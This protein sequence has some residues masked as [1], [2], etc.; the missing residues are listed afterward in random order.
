MLL[1]EHAYS[2]DKQGLAT[3]TTRHVYHV[4]QRE[5]VDYWSSIEREY[6]PW[7]EKR[8]EIRA[9]VISPGGTVRMLDPKT[10]ADAATTQ[11]DNT[12]FS[13]RRTVRAPL[14]GVEAGAVV[15]VEVRT[16]QTR[17]QL[18]AGSVR[19]MVVGQYTQL[20][21]FRFSLEAHRQVPIRTALH[22]IP[23][24]SLRREETGKTVRYELELGPLPVVDRIDFNTPPDSS[25]EKRVE[26]S[27]GASWQALA[28]AYSQTIDEKIADADLSGFMEGVDL[29]GA[30]K[31]IAARLTARLHERV[32]YTGVEFSE[33]EIV[34]VTPAETIARGYG[35]CKD[36]STLLTALLRQ[37]G[38]D[39]RVALLAAGSDP[40]VPEGLPGL[41][42]FNH[43]IVRVGGDEPFWI[44]AT[45]EN[46]RVGVL[47]QMDEGRLVLVAA[48]DTTTLTPTPLS[49]SEDNWLKRTTTLRL[50]DFGRGST[51]VSTTLGGTI[52]QETRAT[53]GTG[54]AF[55]EAVEEGAKTLEG[56]VVFTSA[57]DGSD[58][59]K[60]FQLDAK[61]DKI[62]A[63]ETGFDQAV[64]A[65]AVTDLFDHIPAGASPAMAA[66]EDDSE[67]PREAGVWFSQPHQV[68]MKFVVYPPPLFKP[69]SPPKSV[70]KK[71]GPAAYSLSVNVEDE[72]RLEL[73]YRLDS[74][75][76]RWTAEEA[77]EFLEGA[78]ALY[79][80]EAVRLTFVSE[81]AEMIALGE[82]AA[83]IKKLRT[84]ADENPEDA[85]ARARLARLLLTAGLGDEAKRSAQQAVEQAPDSPGAWTALGWALQH[86]AFGRRFQS[87]WDRDRAVE[88]LRRAVELDPDS[89][90]VS[91]ELAILLEYDRSGTRYAADLTESIAI[92]Q[93]LLEK[94]PVLPYHSNLVVALMRSDRLDE[95]RE[96]VATLN[97][98]AQVN[99]G[100]LLKALEDGPAAMI[101]ETQALT[102]NDT[103]RAQALTSF[104]FQLMRMRRYETAAPV[105]RAAARASASQKDQVLADEIART[106]RYEE[107]E[108]PADDP[109][110]LARR[111]LAALLTGTPEIEEL[112]ELYTERDD[113]DAWSREM[114]RLR[115]ELGG[116]VGLYAS[117]HLP[118]RLSVDILLSKFDRDASVDGTD[119]E[120]EDGRRLLR[121]RSGGM[122]DLFL[123]SQA[124]EH[125]ILGSGENL[126]E[127]GKLVWG[128]LDDG[129]I[130]AA[131]TWLDRATTDLP[132]EESRTPPPEM[133]WPR[134]FDGMSAESAELVRNADA[135]RAAA[136]SMIGRSEESMPAIEILRATAER[137]T[138]AIERN[139]A[140]VALGE[141]LAIAEQ[142][143]DLAKVGEELQSASLFSGEGF[144]FAI[145][146]YVQGQDWEGL[147]D[148]TAQII[149][150]KPSALNAL[151]A[152]AEAETH[153][154]NAEV[155]ADR[156]KKMLAVT[157]ASEDER[158]ASAWIPLL[159]GQADSD[160]LAEL[161]ERLG[162]V[163]TE[164][165]FHYSKSMLQVRT[166]QTD[167]ALDS[168]R[169][170]VGKTRMDALGPK[171]FYLQSLICDS[172]GLPEAS[173][174]AAR[175]ARVAQ[176]QDEYD[177]WALALLDSEQR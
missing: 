68:E 37:A 13:D 49:E 24:E 112:Q 142:W 90:A 97:R 101:L 134:V 102:A 15:E 2:I 99:F 175:R 115:P 151:K 148:F 72:G 141:A 12:I 105:L 155:A 48:P 172:L 64:A 18:D 42:L 25:P 66:F 106:T 176:P 93:E 164:P 21:R 33:A 14:P 28:A 146:G 98:N 83:A 149:D 119:D 17:N 131:R 127:V 147:A 173:R 100:L 171:A 154:G 3:S 45:A 87:D 38:L 19:R 39:A 32:R 143:E 138:V 65:I 158:A 34:P 166:E 75:K 110:T 85:L 30:P 109:K 144:R 73:T 152:S 23:E 117:Q 7:S 128:L 63:V 156:L 76:R 60:P 163:G 137:A 126:A 54:D 55:A 56:E 108:Q 135:A 26:F 79:T 70:E 89:Y 35:D 170:A 44:D 11:Y 95:A 161:N 174:E 41:G 81:S 10:I 61:I 16:E 29:E 94:Q 168:L 120:A 86:D 162:D 58:F 36:K 116:M 107:A 145:Q 104:G 57:T 111:V 136:A 40:D 132:R 103:Q 9:R 118:R 123:L 125:R 91:A 69:V 165:A 52:E 121:V 140:N 88:A 150:E 27:T 51:E 96:H 80:T 62:T 53:Y 133:L 130:D 22:R 20:Q 4:R 1:E 46:A 129:K 82:T 74:G 159:A 78:K 47:P 139:Q 122:P 84:Y 71:L 6:Q 43:V 8:P 5:A 67:E 113:W 153:L 160:T 50:R 167:L 59:S 169:Q 92:Y 31:E 77:R 114:T 177:R 157:Y 124:G